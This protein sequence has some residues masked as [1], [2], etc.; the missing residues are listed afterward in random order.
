MA[1]RGYVLIEA[2]VGKA[3]AVGETVR[4]V[5]H[6][7]ARVVAV[8]TVTGPFDVIVQLEAKD[9]NTPADLTSIYVRARDGRLVQLSNLVR[10][11]ETVAAKELNHFNRQRAAIISQAVRRR[12]RHHA[13][14]GG[15]RSIAA[16]PSHALAVVAP[17]PR[18]CATDGV[19]GEGPGRGQERAGDG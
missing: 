4:G 6:D 10:V 2:E 17:D 12:W 3:K 5:K 8:D 18:G 19:P 13:R 15:S 9:R 14:G 1:V 16:R 11:Q 7:D